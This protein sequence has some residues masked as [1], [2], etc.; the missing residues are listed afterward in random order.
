MPASLAYLIGSP[1][2]ITRPSFATVEVCVL[3]FLVVAC[4]ALVIALVVAA[5]TIVV[6]S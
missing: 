6:W 1:A 2:M 5:C 3:R 4:V